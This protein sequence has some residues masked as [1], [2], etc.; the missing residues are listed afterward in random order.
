MKYWERYMI[1]VIYLIALPHIIYETFKYYN[2]ET[3]NF[4]EW[5][6]V[7]LDYEWEFIKNNGYNNE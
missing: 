4:F 6:F 2:P 7:N 5:L 1:C 3:E